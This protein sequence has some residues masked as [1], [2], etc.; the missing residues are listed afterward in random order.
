MIFKMS[1]L[2]SFGPLQNFQKWKQQFAFLC[3]LH[4]CCFLADF[5]FLNF[6]LINIFFLFFQTTKLQDPIHP[7]QL[8]QQHDPKALLLTLLRTMMMCKVRLMRPSY[9]RFLFQYLCTLAN[10]VLS[11][12]TVCFTVCAPVTGVKNATVATPSPTQRPNTVVSIPNSKHSHI[13]CISISIICHKQN[14]VI[15]SVLDAITIR[16]KNC[17]KFCI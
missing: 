2:L 1:S 12:I 14:T 16:N 5:C 7:N 15:C 11:L 8:L 3:F 10:T 6:A 13:I 17:I 4:C 9:N